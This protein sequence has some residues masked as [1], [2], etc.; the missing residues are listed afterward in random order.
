M[1]SIIIC[2]RKSDIPFVLKENIQ[3]TIGVEY[4]VI[5]IDNSENLYSIFAAYNEGIR[6]SRFPFLCFVHEDVYFHTEN[7]GK[8]LVTHLSDEET[9]II[10]VA[11]GK[12]MTRIP[13]SWSVNGSFINI[14][15]HKKQKKI[16]HIKFPHD[17][18]ENRQTAILLDGV[19]LAARSKLFEKIYFDENISGFHGYDLD[20]CAQ[21]I[22]ACYKNYVV[23]DILLE[24][25]S[26]GN[27]TMQYYANMIQ[28]YKKHKKYL[29]LLVSDI[30]EG[31][32]DEILNVELVHLGKLIRRMATTGFP[33]PEIIDNAEYFINILDSKDAKK[34]LRYIRFKIFFVRL[35]RS[36]KYLFYK[37][38]L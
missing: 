7:W 22:I 33:T 4:E 12:L 31:A 9:G 8:N 29:P 36:P 13:T 16:H 2:S 17:F 28:V 27:R 35:T 11:G 1:I 19:F 25:F 37:A 15:Q 5:V 24:H 30:S 6:R 23:Y 38:K 20:I 21:S 10:G 14:V 34:L 18:L 32:F 3:S 26:F